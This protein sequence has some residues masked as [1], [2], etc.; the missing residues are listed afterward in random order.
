MSQLT[1]ITSLELVEQINNARMNVSE[2]MGTKYVELK[3]K[4]FLEKV[5]EEL[6]VEEMMGL[7][8]EQKILQSSYSNSQ[9][10]EQPMYVIPLSRAKMLMASEVPA[11]RIMVAKYI[12]SLENAIGE[13]T[14][15][16]LKDLLIEAQERDI[17]AL[18]DQ[19]ESKGRSIDNGYKAVVSR[20]KNIIDK[21]KTVLKVKR[22]YEV[23]DSIKV[24]TDTLDTVKDQLGVDTDQ[25][26]LDEISKLQEKEEKSRKYATIWEV[27]I[28]T[29]IRGRWKKLRR[30]SYKNNIKPIDIPNDKWGT[31]KAY[32]AEAW[33]EGYGINIDLL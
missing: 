3:H 24:K 11:V 2:K 14:T 33:R 8:G 9:N 5:R 17:K 18:T 20:K 4:T 7:E 16:Q 15:E 1:T 22:D 21:A 30:L 26:V 25:E 23:V 28:K 19:I 12:E 13:L 31:V 32:P 27:K 10:K 6:K 29:G